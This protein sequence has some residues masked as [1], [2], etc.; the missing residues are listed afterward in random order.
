MKRIDKRIWTRLAKLCVPLYE[1]GAMTRF[2]L[3]KHLKLVQVMRSTE[4]CKSFIQQNIFGSNYD[5]GGGKIQ[6]ILRAYITEKEV[7]KK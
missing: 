5:D 6:S 3:S 7:R 1:I 2:L 4:A